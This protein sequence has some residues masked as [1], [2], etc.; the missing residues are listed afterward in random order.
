MQSIPLDIH[1]I[2]TYLAP[3]GPDIFKMTCALIAGLPIALWIDRRRL[4][5]ESLRQQVSGRKRL[6]QSLI[7]LEHDISQI[8]NELVEAEVTLVSSAEPLQLSLDTSAWDVCKADITNFLPSPELR[9]KIARYYSQ[10]ERFNQTHHLY[11]QLSIG[12]P[13]ASLHDSQSMKQLE[14]LMLGIARTLNEFAPVLLRDL[15][16]EIKGGK[17]RRQDQ[18]N[19]PTGSGVHRTRA[20]P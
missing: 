19:L 12:L 16:A 7:I 14:S 17:A 8:R 11:L 9:Q 15:S 10:I 6:N 2:W 20:T 1:N 13:P 4:R 18:R 3:L 5:R